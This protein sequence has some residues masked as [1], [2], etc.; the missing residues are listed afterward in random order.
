M[1]KNNGKKQLEKYK[2]EKIELE[3]RI[4]DLTEN[5]I[6]STEK[7]LKNFFFEEWKLWMKKEIQNKVKNKKDINFFQSFKEET[8]VSIEI[9]VSKEDESIITNSFIADLKYKGILM[10]GFP[11]PLISLKCE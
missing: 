10:V 9:M 6:P 4:K 11:P 2:L 1:A 3:K 7:E 8:G 5:L